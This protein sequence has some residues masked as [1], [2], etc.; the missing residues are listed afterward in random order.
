MAQKIV[1]LDGT[2]LK[3]GLAV[4]PGAVDARMA[5]SALRDL[6]V[7]D[8]S[9][10]NP[11]EYNVLLRVCSVEEL[12]E[13]GIMKPETFFTK[14]LYNKTHAVIAAIGTEAFTRPDGDY[15]ADRPAVG[16]L[17]ITA[18]YA[19][20]VYRDAENNL[21]RYA[22]DKDVISIVKRGA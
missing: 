15:I 6:E 19:G 12:T 9:D 8:P 14:E 16:D 7:I 1:G 5:A 21:Y 11:L 17:V 2:E 13:G 22:K 3:P 20:N 4:P 18:K 10:Q